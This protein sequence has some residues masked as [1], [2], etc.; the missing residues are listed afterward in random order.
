MNLEKIID[1]EIKELS[2]ELK[3][4]RET[5][6]MRTYVR[7]LDGLEKLIRLNERIKMN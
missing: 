3:T 1:N 5:G 7:L 4:A 6:E 2:E